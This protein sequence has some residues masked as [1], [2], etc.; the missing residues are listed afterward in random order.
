MSSADKSQQKTAE[1]LAV[2]PARAATYHP[3]EEE[4]SITCAHNPRVSKVFGQDGSQAHQGFF[5]ACE[6]KE[7]AVVMQ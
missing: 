6:E 1:P 3:K 2:G 4:S 5:V 7:G